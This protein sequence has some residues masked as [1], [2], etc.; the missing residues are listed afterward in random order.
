MPSYASYNL[1]LAKEKGLENHLLMG[2]V[3]KGLFLGD[4][5]YLLRG[6]FGAGKRCVEGTGLIPGKT[7]VAEHFQPVRVAFARQQF[8][9]TFVN[10]FG[11]FAA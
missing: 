6:R 8:R 10:A 2:L 7:S 9:R 5:A 3:Q 4:S 1:L 11:M